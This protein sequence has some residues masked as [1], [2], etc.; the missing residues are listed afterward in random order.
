MATLDLTNPVDQIRLRVGDTTDLHYL[1]DSAYSY[2]LSE[3]GNNKYKASVL[4]AQWIL[5]QM[6]Y[7][8]H[9]KMANLEVWGKETF[10]SYKQFL[11]M[12]IRD[13]A[14]AQ[15]SPIP[16]GAGLTTANP[17]IQFTKDWNAN[18]VGGTQSERLN[19]TAQFAAGV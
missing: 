4:A 5:A 17:L 2:A 18:Y 19:L 6:A 9:R 16:Y 8:G 12:L 1:P 10:D 14:I 11:V 13:P 15:M 7:S 3:S